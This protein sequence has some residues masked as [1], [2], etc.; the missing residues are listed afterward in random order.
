V[1]VSADIG[2]A[3]SPAALNVR[4]NGLIPASS[5]G[6]AVTTTAPGDATRDGITVRPAERADLLAVSRIERESFPQPWPF[7]VF[8]GL[9]GQPG[10][11]VADTGTGVAGF[12][13][14]DTVS[15]HGE[16]AGHVKDFA[17]HPAYRGQGL[18]TRLLDRALAVLDR[19]HVR[20]AKLEVR[21]SNDAAI[22][23]Y[24]R[25]GFEPHHIVS[26]YYDNG[27]AAAVFVV[28]LA[29]RWRPFA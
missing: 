26:Q 21:R 11:L 8:Q 28:K 2:P 6:R 20:R 25:F 29:D 9:L 22:S 27:E 18:G 24:R 15:H 12:I 5:E 13:V 19:P 23:L 4:P 17:V 1:A 3:L 10:F 7:D 16:P 14:A